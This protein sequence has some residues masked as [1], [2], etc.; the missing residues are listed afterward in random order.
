MV[1][2]SD[3]NKDIRSISDKVGVAVFAYD[4]IHN[5]NINNE[6]HYDYERVIAEVSR[7]QQIA[8][9]EAE[10]MLVEWRI[11]KPL[12]GG[13]YE[14]DVGGTTR[15]GG[16]INYGSA[17]FSLSA[18]DHQ[19]KYHELAHS[20]QK[21]YNLFD[22]DKISHLY[23]VAGQG[24]K[25]TED[26][27][28][29]LLDKPT[30]SLYLNE[31]HSET[32]GYAAL[33]LRAENRRDFLWQASSAYNSG[34]NSNLVAILS[35]GK[36]EYGTDSENNSKFYATKS[37]MKPMIKAIWK[38]RKE[39]RKEEFFDEKGVLKD[40]KLAR[41][42]EEVVM[43][44]AY[45]PRTLKSFFD[46][47]VMDDHSKD[48]KGW[49][50]DVLKSIVQMPMALF[51][52]VQD[53]NVAETV[54]SI[55]KHKSLVAEQNRKIKKFAA[56]R[57]DYGDPEL[58]ALKEYERLQVKFSLMDNKYPGN[59]I[60]SILG[61]KVRNGLP[62]CSV[63]FLADCYGESSSQKKALEKDLKSVRKIILQNKENPYFE[64]LVQ[65]ETN[66]M[67]LRRMLQ[68]KQ[69]NPQEEVTAR[70]VAKEKIYGLAT[71]PV[72]RRIEEVGKFADKYHLNPAI[73]NYLLETMVK[74]PQALENT[75]N[76]KALI[77]EQKFSNDFLGLKKRKFVKEFNH[78]L[79]R[80]G[81]SYYSER[82]NPV[83]PEV[84]Q[85]LSKQPVEKFAE[86]IA[87]ME[88]QER[89]ARNNGQ[90]V[91]FAEE[92]PMMQAQVQE[93]VMKEQAQ[94]DYVREA[95]IQQPVLSPREQIDAE[96]MKLG[97]AKGSYMLFTQQDKNLETSY[98]AVSSRPIEV[99]LD[100]KKEAER[101]GA[102]KI[103]GQNNGLTAVYFAKQDVYLV[104]ANPEV[105]KVMERSDC[106]DVGL[107]VM[108]S[109]GEKILNSIA[110]QE[111]WQQVRN[112]GEDIA[113]KKW[114]EQRCREE[115]IQESA[116]KPIAEKVV[117]AA[118]VQVK[119]IES[120]P[121]DLKNLLLEKSGRGTMSSSAPVQKNKVNLQT[122]RFR[123]ATFDR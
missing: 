13:E 92:K 16:G 42:C 60:T 43:K 96:M 69:Q 44:N 24:L 65:T 113:Q 39:G 122:V 53:G 7:L 81:H 50:S 117:S 31:M 71:Y 56:K 104:T 20:L 11:L 103:M 68:E 64:K 85:E 48:E 66:S 2:V 72:K 8:S 57:V 120:N 54:K 115:K 55:F 93:P 87:E 84:L 5:E 91:K 58:T 109:N 15:R 59:S 116:T 9:E 41:L 80:V 110:K 49:R 61:E 102:D 88:A 23:S 40:E 94:Q 111:E 27:E 119:T 73:K 98:D 47:N 74:N 82:A 34:I 10:K 107:G 26:K 86:K 14:V 18:K 6:F 32:F 33:M 112:V 63:R 17:F 19:V 76:R 100:N 75:Q 79:D 99:F 118:S 12:P 3:I 114:E 106:K 105:A 101:I 97:V 67:D 90:R 121:K 62:D 21:Q 89:E 38:I 46:Y 35:F 52:I 30:Y 22:D 83:Y 108:F 95:T 70:L 25:S 36:T 78:L 123:S 51:E 45:S 37:V 1:K 28:D 4:D 29:K 77:S